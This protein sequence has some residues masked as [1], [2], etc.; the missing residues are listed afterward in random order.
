MGTSALTLVGGSEFLLENDCGPAQHNGA[1]PR[2]D[3]QSMREA[4]G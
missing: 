4:F 1:H 3:A 2:R